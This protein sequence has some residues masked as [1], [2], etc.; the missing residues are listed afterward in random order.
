M[1]LQCCVGF[2][3]DADLPECVYP[4]PL[5]PASLSYLFLKCFMKGG[6]LQSVLWSVLS[7]ED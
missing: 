2:R 3:H 1:P 7:N 5:E 6:V 4:L